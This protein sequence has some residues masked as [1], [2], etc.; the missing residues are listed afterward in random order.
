MDICILHNFSQSFAEFIL[1]YIVEWMQEY[2]ND[3][4]K[5]LVT[6][7]PGSLLTLAL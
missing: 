2:I 7:K 3:D 4:L 1:P 5:S 6:W